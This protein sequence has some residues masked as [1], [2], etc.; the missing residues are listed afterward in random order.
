GLALCSPYLRLVMLVPRL[1][2]AM[3]G[4]LSRIAP[5]LPLK[6]ELRVE[7]LSRDEQW[8]QDTRADRLIRRVATPRWF[9][10]SSA[11]QEALLRR[12]PEITVPVLI[13]HGGED[14]IADPLAAQELYDRLG[15]PDKAPRFY[16]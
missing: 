9:C 13:V 11:A 12:A 16:D 7:M 1:K 3:A 8:Q 6:S 2:R 14:P 5:A 10:T 4:T 15:S